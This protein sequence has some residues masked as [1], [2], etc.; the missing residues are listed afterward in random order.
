MDSTIGEA[1]Y[2][3][4]QYI[5]KEPVFEKLEWLN[6]TQWWKKEEIENLQLSKLKKI[7]RNAYSHIPYYQKTLKPYL[8]IIHHL[9][10]VSELISLPFLTKQKIHDNFH[11]LQNPIYKGRISTESTSGSTGDPMKFV[12]DRNG[13]AFARALSYREHQWYDLHIGCR[14]ARFYGIPMDFKAKHKEKLKDFLMNRKRFCVFDLSEDSLKRYYRMINRYQPEYIYGYTSAIFEFIQFM[15][16]NNL[17]FKKD[18]LKAVIVTSEVLLIDHRKII[19]SYLNVPVINEY[20]CSEVG[21]IAAECP[22]H[23]LHISA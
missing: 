16:N 12:H 15:R 4:I 20:G 23:G 10:S 18:F 9:Q 14:E 6:S 8:D 5:R 3:T 17:R 22:E 13:G 11:L 21:I 19:E 2:R 1:I 7:L